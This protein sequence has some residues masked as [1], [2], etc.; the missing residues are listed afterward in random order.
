MVS[1]GEVL[2]STAAKTPQKTAV[3]F[4]SRKTTY[5]ALDRMTDGLAAQ[6][7]NAGIEPGDRVALICINCTAFVVAYY[8]ILKAG[9]VVVPIN[10]LLNA[11]EVRHIIADSGSRGV[12]YHELLAPMVDGL[13][14][15]LEEMRVRI[16]LSNDDEANAA[17][18]APPKR[19]WK[20]PPINP[21]E[22]LAAVMYTS[23]TTG[24]AKGAMMT[25]ANLISNAA[26]YTVHMGVTSRDVTIVVLPMFHTFAATVGTNAS[27]YIGATITVLVRFTPDEVARV[28]EEDGATVFMGVP[29][30]YTIFC[31]LQEGKAPPL[32]RLRV[33]VSGG[34]ALPVDIHRRF[35]E[36]FGVGIREGYGLTECSPITT[37]TPI[38]GVIK[39][40]SI[41]PA[42]EGVEVRLVDDRGNDV[43]AGEVGEL[44][45][46]GPNVMKGYWENEKATR[47]AFFGEWFRTGDLARVDEDGYY[48][49]VD[50]KKDL[51]IVNGLNVYPRHVEE[52]IY[53]HPAVA[54]VAVVP[55][56]DDLHGEVPRAVIALKEGA[57]ATEREIIA[58]CRKRLGR[59][60]VPRVVEF[61][62]ALPKN[63]TGKIL[64][65]AIPP[66]VR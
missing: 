30:M 17:L 33:A 44:V 23:G 45:V 64:K 57:S 14:T 9:A 36:R 50:R 7:R 3:V 46:R 15:A 54:E 29:S 41:G 4:Q 35:E 39:P 21:V 51:I 60:Q 10:V 31:N 40:G 6:L 59:F 43:P 58:F 48:Y 26:A 49:I 12:I 38:T 22:D 16:R 62:P 13:G 56:K 52:V 28:M 19:V 24:R 66:R 2:R 47:E 55:E 27:I 18:F 11:D 32:E 53:Q 61:V 37:M 34:A 63:A 8:G 5:R 65:R 1:L 20:I 42:L 25:H